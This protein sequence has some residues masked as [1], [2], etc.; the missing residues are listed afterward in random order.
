MRNL[1]T[2]L[3]VIATF[4][5]C[6][7][8]RAEEWG[9]LTG[10]FVL[11]G[12]APKVAPLVV[13]PGAGCGAVKLVDESVVIGPNKGIK[14][15]VVYLFLKEGEKAPA[16]HPDYDKTAKVEVALDNDKC[17]FE[18]RITLLRTSQTLVVGN[19]D[20][21]GHNTNLACLENK[22]ENPIIPP[23]ASVKFSFPK[24]E[25][26]PTNVSCNIHP[27]MNAKVLIRDNP[28]FAVTDENGKFTIKK[29]PEGKFIF[30]FWHERIGYLSTGLIKDG[31]P[32]TVTKGRLDVVITPKGTD[33]GKIEVGADAFKK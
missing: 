5:A 7:F 33:L 20:A 32:L 28:Y 31:K 2:T 4:L 30:Q 18:P 12:A 13:P 22:P 17:R 1:L 11:S 15:V 6:G 29:L 27:W 10:Q 26:L 19:K 16:A 21:V 24:S 8:V 14:N 3:S 9:D 23:G 25:R